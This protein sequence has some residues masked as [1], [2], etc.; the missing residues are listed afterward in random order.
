MTSSWS[1]AEAPVRD[2]RARYAAGETL[3]ALSRQIGVARSTLREVVNGR[4]WQDASVP[5][6]PK[7]RP[8]KKLTA[9]DITEIR[10]RYAAGERQVV[11]AAAFAIHQGHVSTIVRR[12]SA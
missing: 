1:D 12:A 4:C 5:A 11:I 6:T 7:R 8:T 3:S 10:R 2:V 9:G